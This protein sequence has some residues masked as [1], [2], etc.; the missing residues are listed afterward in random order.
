MAVRL[1]TSVSAIKTS[2]ATHACD[3]VMS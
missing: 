3:V 2:A 1:T